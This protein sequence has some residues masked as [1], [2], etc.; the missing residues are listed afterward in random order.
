M[1]NEEMD[2]AGIHACAYR[3]DGGSR[4]RVEWRGTGLWAVVDTGQ[5]LNRDGEWEYEPLPS[6]R[7]DDFMA[8]CRFPLNE[9]LRLALAVANPLAS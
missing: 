3:L 5:C 8:R 1:T 2:A 6:N 7:D 9:A 4:I